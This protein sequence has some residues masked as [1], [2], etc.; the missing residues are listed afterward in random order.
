MNKK[1]RNKEISRPAKT[2]LLFSGLYIIRGLCALV[3]PL[4]MVNCPEL[5]KL[6]NGTGR[7]DA[8]I[9]E[10]EEAKDSISG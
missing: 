3:L 6:K 2:N 4:L 5:E 9:S 1:P 10:L 8:E 7:Q